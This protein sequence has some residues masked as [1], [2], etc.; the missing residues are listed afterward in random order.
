MNKD[1]YS[2]LRQGTNMF[3]N[4]CQVCMY[5]RACRLCETLR[6]HVIHLISYKTVL[7]KVILRVVP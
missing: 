6:F 5:F 3:R 2:R 4:V 7:V 1:V